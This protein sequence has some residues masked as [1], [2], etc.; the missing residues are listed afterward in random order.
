MVLD[1]ETYSAIGVQRPYDTVTVSVKERTVLL[2]NLMLCLSDPGF[3]ILNK[4]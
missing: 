3:D 4:D 2:K 1:K